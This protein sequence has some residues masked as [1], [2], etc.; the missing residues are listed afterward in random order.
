M[1]ENYE[2]RWVK[3]KSQW[4][5]PCWNLN[6]WVS[7]GFSWKNCWR[8]HGRPENIEVPGLAGR[9]WT[10]VQEINGRASNFK[11][12][13]EGGRGTI[14]VAACQ[15]GISKR[16]LTTVDRGAWGPFVSYQWP[17]DLE[18]QMHITSWVTRSQVHL[19]LWPAW[20]AKRDTVS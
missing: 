5:F 18:D 10:G 14:E 16:K 19:D 9:L 2:K 6:S 4:G 13:Q 15:A 12:L 11:R 1:V 3:L 20:C 17:Y 7:D 8:S